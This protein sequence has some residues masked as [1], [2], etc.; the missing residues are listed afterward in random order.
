MR[1]L[2]G[3]STVSVVALWVLTCALFWRIYDAWVDEWQRRRRLRRACRE[4]GACAR[5]V[6]R[7]GAVARVAGAGDRGAACRA[8][9]EDGGEAA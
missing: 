8:H 3:F 6:Q 2:D 7:Q 4:W 9:D 5:R 1:W